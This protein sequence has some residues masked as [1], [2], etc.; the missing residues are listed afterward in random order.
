[1]NQELSLRVAQTIA[2]VSWTA[3]G[4]L[5]ALRLGEYIGPQWTTVAI[6]LL[7]VAMASALKVSRMRM[8]Q[9]LIEVFQAGA[10]AADS[11]RA[12]KRPDV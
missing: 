10:H 9:T 2:F 7:A 1:M 5:A 8:T 12:E 6:L 4:V 11:R 3:A